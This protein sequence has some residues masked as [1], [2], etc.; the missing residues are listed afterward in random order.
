[1]KNMDLPNI[2]DLC[3]NFKYERL[4]MGRFVFK[5]GDPSN[6][7]FY[8]IISGEVAVIVKQEIGNWG[9]KFTQVRKPKKTNLEA[10]VSTFKRATVI[11]DRSL[12]S[13]PNLE[14][15]DGNSFLSFSDLDKV[16]VRGTRK[17]TIRGTIMMKPQIKFP[18]QDTIIEEDYE[19][20]ER[21]KSRNSDDSPKSNSSFGTIAKTVQKFQ[22]GLHRHRQAKI[23]VKEASPSESEDE[24]TQ[25]F[26][27]MAAR[28]G[29]ILRYMRPGEGFGELALK[30]NT[31]RTASIMTKTAT[32]FL[33]LEKQFYDS[34][35]GKMEKE[36][37]EFIKSCFPL[38]STSISS[39][40][41][42]NYLMFCL[43]V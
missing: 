3:K 40:A 15:S 21:K 11:E 41:N 20:R 27:Q 4:P 37:E 30:E 23:E 28:Y 32:E 5:Q 43:K 38:L 34:I 10:P 35:C 18:E 16:N 33:V 36:R 39:S 8:V 26:E 2:L 22:Q 29:K 7:K 12:L 31:P 25:E 14:V 24:E 19:T 9:Q 42:L 6:N 1:M 17:G 13:I